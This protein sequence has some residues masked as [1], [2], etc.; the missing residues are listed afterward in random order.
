MFEDLAR[1][2]VPGSTIV[3]L[4][5]A[6][7]LAA[8]QPAC[9]PKPVF[10]KNGNQELPVIDL[11]TADGVLTLCAYETALDYKVDKLLGCWTVDA[12]TAAL[13]ASAAKTIPGR[14]RRTNLDAQNCIDGY[15]IAP[16]PPE[17]HRPFFATSTDGA[18]AAI[19]T[20]RLLYIFATNTK[21]KVAEIELVKQDAADDT[22]VGN[23]PWGL[24]YS[25]DTLFVIGTDAGPFTGVWVFK[26]DGSR[27]GRISTDEDV[28]NIFN[29]GYGILGRD[30]V[31]LVDAG[32][33][34]MTI[35]TGANTAKQS[36]KRTTSYAPCTKDQ[37]EQWTR[38]EDIK[39]GACKRTLDAKYAPYVNMSPVQLPSGDIITPLSGPA[40]GAMAV[41][42]P[43][44]L[45]ETRRLKLARCP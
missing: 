13:G 17:D 26:Q 20:E 28:L 12:T 5:L 3:V 15:C 42:N 25:G 24:L 8:A 7:T 22:S 9:L 27:V 45:T 16:I 1:F 41:L 35:V 21:A 39:S 31:A 6:T 30:K 40:Q 38:S 44:G 2:E 34:N 29:G 37:F 11:D 32:L 43:A 23:E 18:H 14:G 4:L 10:V 19:M 33:Q 36:T